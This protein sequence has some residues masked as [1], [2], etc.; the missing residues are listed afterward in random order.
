MPLIGVEQ[1]LLDWRLINKHHFTWKTRSN[2]SSSAT[3]EGSRVT[4]IEELDLLTD[5][6]ELS[7]RGRDAAGWRS[8]QME[9]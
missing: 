1:P 2:R 3:A 9:H 5:G 8:S 4:S 7:A 6:I